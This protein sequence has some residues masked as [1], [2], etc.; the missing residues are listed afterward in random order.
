M[1]E[2]KSKDQELMTITMEECGELIQACSKAIRC[3]TYLNNDSLIEE[4]TDVFCM[5][6]L[7]VERG[8]ITTDELNNGSRIKKLKLI[9]YSNIFGDYNEAKVD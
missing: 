6:E 2:F 9:K 8:C 7:L 1:S 5:I 3:G 4:I